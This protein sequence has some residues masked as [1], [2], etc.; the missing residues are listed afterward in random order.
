[1]NAKKSKRADLE[2]RRSVFFQLG[3][4][5][6]ISCVLMAFEWAVSDQSIKDISSSRLISIDEEMAEITIQ[7]VEKPPMPDLPKIADEL[8]VVENTEEA[9]DSET[10][11][12]EYF[13]T[14]TIIFSEPTISTEPEPEPFPYV[15]VEDKPVFGK[16]DADLIN[17][18]A[19]SIVYPP[20]A[21]EIG[22]KGKVFV[23]FVISKDG[24]VKDVK[25]VRGIHPLLDNEA[26]R[27]VKNMPNWKPGMQRKVPVPVSFI[28]P[29]KYELE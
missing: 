16:G 8:T 19:K 13:A 14:T 6:S 4:V 12:N 10:P 29:I 17:Y 7:E 28:V 24:S 11:S 2:K 9:D 25:I 1:M 20:D 5:I 22:L 18:L 26:L 23:E 21:V 3:I 15:L 27:V